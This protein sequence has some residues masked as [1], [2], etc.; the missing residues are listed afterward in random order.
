MG[1]TQSK[2]FK[3]GQIFVQLQDNNISFVAGQVIQGQIHVNQTE[4]FDCKSFTVG[5]YGIEETYFLK[6]HRSGKH[7]HTEKHFGR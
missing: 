1:E 5:L 2:T 4:G 6:L 7:S 3:G